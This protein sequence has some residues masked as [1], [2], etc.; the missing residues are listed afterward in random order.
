MMAMPP[1]TPVAAAGSETRLNMRVK[2]AARQA[3]AQESCAA[4]GRPPQGAFRTARRRR[5]IV[6]TA[7]AGEP[8]EPNNQGA[9]P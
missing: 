3:R 7:G 2:E 1:P 6:A 8:R 4:P 5:R 9:R